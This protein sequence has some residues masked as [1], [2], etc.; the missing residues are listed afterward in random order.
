MLCRSKGNPKFADT[1]LVSGPCFFM[2]LSWMVPGTTPHE[3][4]RKATEKSNTLTLLSA[5]LAPNSCFLCFWLPWTKG[6]I[7]KKRL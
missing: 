4:R 5:A 6:E 1:S 7:S 3:S 2:F